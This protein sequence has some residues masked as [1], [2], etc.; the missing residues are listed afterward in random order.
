M[1]IAFLGCTG[2]LLAACLFP[3]ASDDGP[4]PPVQDETLRTQHNE[5]QD[6]PQ[7]VPSG[8]RQVRPPLPPAR[9]NRNGFQSVQVN[10]DEDGNNIVGDAANEPSIAVD[11]LDSSRIAIGWRQFD[12]IQSNFRQA[13]WGFTQDGGA[14][15]TF[16]GVLAE[17]VFRS[18]PVLDFDAL[19]T[20]YYYSLT[21]DFC[22]DMYISDDGGQ[23]WPID[24]PAAGGDKA[25]CILHSSSV[26]APSVPL[27]SRKSHSVPPNCRAGLNRILRSRKNQPTAAPSMPSVNSIASRKSP[28]GVK[29]E[30]A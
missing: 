29:A 28:T 27:G 14:V 10:V 22:C 21:G 5:G 15:W 4:D 12:T 16:P 26:A 11:P 18:D 19:G 23:T 6:S 17:N 24:N 3:A 8:P 9:L 25:W 7:W 2:V 13:G 30:T 20:F 1:N